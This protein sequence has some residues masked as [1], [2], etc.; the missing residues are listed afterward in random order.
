MIEVS[1]SVLLSTLY[2]PN[3]KMGIEKKNVFSGSIQRESLSYLLFMPSSSVF[4][5]AAAAAACAMLRPY[6]I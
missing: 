1:I 6:V 2:C 5:R 4:E 3:F